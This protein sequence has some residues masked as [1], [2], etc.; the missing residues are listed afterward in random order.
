MAATTL[1]SFLAN[2]VHSFVLMQ[3]ELLAYLRPAHF[4]V[5]R[6]FKKNRAHVLFTIRF[7]ASAPVYATDAPHPENH[8]GAVLQ[9]LKGIGKVNQNFH[10]IKAVVL[11]DGETGRFE[12]WYLTPTLKWVDVVELTLLPTASK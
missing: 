3:A 1:F 7:P 10:V 8:A 9:I 12:A 4:L 5:G 11:R 2:L 6:L